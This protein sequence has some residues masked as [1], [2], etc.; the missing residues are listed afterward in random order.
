MG[1]R[2]TADDTALVPVTSLLEGRAPRTVTRLCRNGKIPGAKKV[3]MCWMI[4]RSAWRAFIG[5]RPAPASTAEADL[6]RAG[7]RFAR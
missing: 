2:T 4:T 7:F 1:I 5:E 3:G 6:V